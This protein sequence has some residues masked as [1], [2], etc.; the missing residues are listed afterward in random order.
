MIIPYKEIYF[1]FN[2]TVLCM[3]VIPKSVFACMP[4]TANDVFIARI[5]PSQ[6]EQPLTDST[7][8]YDVKMKQVTFPFRTI[9][10]LFNYSKPSQWQSS[11]KIPEI[12]ESALVIGL[13]YTPD[14]QKPHSYTITTL[15]LLTCQNDTLMIEKPMV[16]FTAWN[17][18]KGNCRHESAAEVSLLNGFLD[19]DQEYYLKKLRAKYPA[20]E[21]FSSQFPLINSAPPSYW[22]HIYNLFA[23]I[24]TWFIKIMF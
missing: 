8:R 15:S 18:E 24:K 17:R 6:P 7:S 23:H 22:S 21:S 11:F 3:L 14:G 20:C 16:S 9:K 10:T 5:Y 13:A 4:L 12:R 1:T 2:F 19:H